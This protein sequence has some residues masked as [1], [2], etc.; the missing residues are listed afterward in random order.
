M[1]PAA[2]LA[3]PS[4]LARAT[5]H[6]RRADPTLARV[7]DAVGPCR[8]RVER[9]GGA[10]ASLLEAILYQQLAGSAAAAIHRRLQEAI[11]RPHPR[12]EDVARLS[13]ARLRRIGFSRQKIG[14]TRD[15]TRRV[16]DGLP[17]SRLGRLEDE[18]VI[19]ALT[20]VHGIGRWTAEM[21][22]MFRL[23][24][25]DVLP[26]DDYGIRKGMQGAYGWRALP[27]PD[28]MRRL[29]EAW[30]PWR[31]VA[32]WYLWQSLRVGRE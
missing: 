23:G 17:L 13:H 16:Q 7:I 6:L 24:R 2:T 3:M 14:Y 9:G 31:S 18:A 19:D 30:R 26:V 28:R 22:L 21:F 8:F 20:Q 4:A 25:P 15:L 5:R 10:Y 29:A 32:C 11:G 27:K 12:P 1:R